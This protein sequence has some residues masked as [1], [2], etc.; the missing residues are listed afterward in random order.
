MV[1]RDIGAAKL[2]NARKNGK[3]EKSS[4]K[5]G[6]LQRGLRAWAGSA[7]WVVIYE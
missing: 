4:V 2:A 1:P 3:I 6:E 5:F 7:H